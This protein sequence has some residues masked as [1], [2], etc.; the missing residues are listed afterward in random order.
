[1]D[2]DGTKDE[3]LSK[4][5]KPYKPR[6]E[7]AAGEDRKQVLS[8]A[9]ISVWPEREVLNTDAAMDNQGEQH[10]QKSLFASRTSPNCLFQLFKHLT[11]EQKEVVQEIG[12]GGLL[13]LSTD[14]LASSLSCWLA[15]SYEVADQTLYVDLS[16][17]KKIEINSYDVHLTLGLPCSDI[18]VVEA[19]NSDDSDESY[20]NLL[21][22]WRESW[23]IQCGSP[24]AAAMLKA[25]QGDKS[26]GEEFRRNFVILT[27]ST[28]LASTQTRYVNFKILKSLIN[29]EQIKELDWSGYTI[30]KL[31]LAMDSWKAK[32]DSFFTGSMLFL[33]MLYLD[34]VITAQG[35]IVPRD[36]PTLKGWTSDCICQRLDWEVKHG[37]F[38][39]GRVEMPYGHEFSGSPNVALP[40][41]Q[42]EDDSV[43]IGEEPDYERD[44]KELGKCCATV[45]VAI[46]NLKR[47]ITQVSEKYP[48][49]AQVNR[50]KAMATTIF[51]G[52]SSLTQKINQL[53][54]MATT[55]VD[56][57]SG[58]KQ[59]E[60]SQIVTQE[61]R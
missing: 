57:T 10:L 13:H 9:A 28:L 11:D 24:T 42:I 26:H 55:L 14:R 54:A 29:V 5:A 39:K 53:T 30:K 49:S 23:N 34:R 31:N 48:D 36:F 1:M 18:E 20:K 22:R 44:L 8:P 2:N 40:T 7:S 51:M 50:I 56:K 60:V 17:G 19:G 6:K 33:Q 16:R 38:G 59:F 25:M 52:N 32:T 4:R 45:A 37:G 27:V 21:D 35:R 15:N 43:P 47:N 58:T 41:Q 3:R 46:I 12:F 61:S